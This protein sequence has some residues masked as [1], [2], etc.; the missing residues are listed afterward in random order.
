[1]KC[2][3]GQDFQSFAPSW[4]HPEKL[5]AKQ[6]ISAEQLIYP[7]TSIQTEIKSKFEMGCV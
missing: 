2:N 1:M 5:F 6:L 3:A 7:G 4:I